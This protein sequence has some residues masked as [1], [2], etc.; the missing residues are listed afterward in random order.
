[1]ELKINN[2]MNVDDRTSLYVD[3]MQNRFKLVGIK[4][5]SAE[6]ILEKNADGSVNRKIKSPAHIEITFAGLDLVISFYGSTNSYIRIENKYKL[7]EPHDITFINFISNK[8]I[9]MLDVDSEAV[10]LEFGTAPYKTV[11]HFL[12]SCEIK[13][14]RMQLC[15]QQLN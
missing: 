5:N 3:M 15:I 2:H 13:I 7:Y 1:M 6:T 4:I 8:I 12:D 9:Q 14:F 10:F 11:L